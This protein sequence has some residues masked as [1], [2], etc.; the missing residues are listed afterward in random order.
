MVTLPFS[1]R[2]N[3]SSSP[4]AAPT[5]SGGG[6]VGCARGRGAAERAEAQSS[7]AGSGCRTPGDVSKIAGGGT[8]ASCATSLDAV[9]S[10]PF[11]ND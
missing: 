5:G 9:Y 11:G 1:F 3:F 6:L 7:D 10:L 8:Q 4:V 2:Y